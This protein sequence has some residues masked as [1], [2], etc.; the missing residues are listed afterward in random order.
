MFSCRIVKG[1]AF[2][3]AR[4]LNNDNILTALVVIKTINGLVLCLGGFLTR[5]IKHVVC[6]ES[7]CNLL[8]R[9]TVIKH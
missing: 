3:A 4:L 6:A 5:E 7:L 2:L 1:N 9:H 8:S